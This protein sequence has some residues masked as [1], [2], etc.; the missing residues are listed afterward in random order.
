ME[1][2][3]SLYGYRSLGLGNLRNSVHTYKY[4]FN[5]KGPGVKNSKGRKEQD[6]GMCAFHIEVKGNRTEKGKLIMQS[7]VYVRVIARE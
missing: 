5:F 7:Y 2:E 4:S 1:V 3:V 6:K